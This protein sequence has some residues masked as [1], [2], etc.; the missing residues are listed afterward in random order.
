MAYW[1]GRIAAVANLRLFDPDQGWRKYGDNVDED[2]RTT[3]VGC[4]R[5][6]ELALSSALNASNLTLLTGA[7]S[8]YS[9]R[10]KAGLLTAPAMTDLWDAV[11]AKV[12]TAVLNEVVSLIPTAAG[13]AKNIEKLLTLAKLYVSLFDDSNSKKISDFIAVAEVAILERVDFVDG[14]T[15]LSSHR[16]L[17]LRVARR[18]IRKPRTKIFTTNYDLC[19]EYA[20]QSQQ[21]VVIDG[22]SHSTP[23]VY[24]RAHF[25]YDTV[26]RTGPD[27]APDYIENVFQLFKLHGSI[28]WRRGASAIVRSRSNEDGTPVLIFPRDTKYQEAFEVPYL[29][30]MGALQTALR[31]PDTA[32]LISGFGFAD[33]HICKPILAAL[34]A[35]ISLRV[36]LCDIA[37]LNDDALKLNEDI[38]AKS[39]GKRVQNTY[40][41]QFIALA[42]AGDTRIILLNGRFE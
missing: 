21:F 3:F 8:S 24:D 31:E 32:L 7:G 40:F 5:D 38:I 41:D 42:E 37:F 26:R 1:E 14:A 18:G 25:S 28:D 11:E 16:A 12:T 39:A 2:G 6:L 30:M 19:F 34:Q 4:S 13:I 27:D 33:D 20:A 35:N 22:F 36:I 9:A 15:D 10:N 23:Q 29:D 17:I